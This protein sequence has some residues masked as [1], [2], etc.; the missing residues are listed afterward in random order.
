MMKKEE[1]EEE[2]KEEV[3]HVISPTITIITTTIIVHVVV[4]VVIR[5]DKSLII[6]FAYYPPPWASFA[7]LSPQLHFHVHLLKPPLHFFRFALLNQ[8]LAPCRNK[9]THVKQNSLFQSL[10][11]IN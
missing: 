2:E 4:V 5:C 1:E 9:I 11:H 8:N 7:S 10:P 3:F 6:L